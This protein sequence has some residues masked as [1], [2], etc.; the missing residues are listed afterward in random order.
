MGRGI[1]R[2]AGGD[3]NLKSN[4]IWPYYTKSHIQTLCTDSFMENIQ[5]FE[6]IQ[7]MY[8]YTISK[9]L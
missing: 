9:F 2:G 1:L 3:E 7:N 4:F 5:S 6:H 8:M